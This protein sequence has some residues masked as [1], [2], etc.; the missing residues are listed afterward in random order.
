MTIKKH[1]V[2][3]QIVM[4]LLVVILSTVFDEFTLLILYMLLSPLLDK[5][6]ISEARFI[7]L[8]RKVIGINTMLFLLTG[9]IAWQ[10]YSLWQSVFYILITAALPE[11]W[12]FRGYLQQ[13]TGNKLKSVFLVSILFS[14]SHAISVTPLQG[15][16]VFIP[17]LVFGY[18]Y[19]LSRDILLV[20]MLHLLSNLL[21]QLYFL[22]LI[23]NYFG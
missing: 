10:D 18:I 3:L 12:F 22:D 4:F 23:A 19:L 17:S 2:T 13:R 11:E 6:W 7:N 5:H 16:L 20:I 14:I 21:Y 8:D 9:Y 15:L 1:I